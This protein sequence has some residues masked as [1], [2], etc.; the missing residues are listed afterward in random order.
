MGASSASTATIAEHRVKLPPM[1]VVVSVAYLDYRQEGR[2][3]SRTAQIEFELLQTTENCSFTETC[4]FEAGPCRWELG[5]G[6]DI[7]DS[8][9]TS[10]IGTTGQ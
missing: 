9:L 3:I 5:R 7:T 1:Q 2:D 10:V 8:A 4:N 6:G